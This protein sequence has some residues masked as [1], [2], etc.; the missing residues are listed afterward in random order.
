MGALG[1]VTLGGASK[2]VS[3]TI[4]TVL[5]SDFVI[6]NVVKLNAAVPVAFAFSVASM[7]VTPAT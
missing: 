3:F 6:S 1:M 4:H 7:T 5:P 2:S